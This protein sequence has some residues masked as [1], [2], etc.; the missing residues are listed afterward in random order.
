MTKDLLLLNFIKSICVDAFA[1]EEQIKL[2]KESLPSISEAYKFSKVIITFEGVSANVAPEG[3]NYSHVLFDSNDSDPDCYFERVFNTPEGSK[4]T[5]VFYASNSN[6]WSDDDKESIESLIQLIYIVHG[7]ARIGRLLD[8]AASTDGDTGLPNARGFLSVTKALEADGLLS[9]YAVMFLNI[10]NFRIFT[11]REGNEAGDKLIKDYFAKLK[12]FCRKDEY[13]ARP[14]GDNG[15]MLIKKENYNDVLLKINE[16]TVPLT[17]FTQTTDIHVDTWVGVYFFSSDISVSEAMSFASIALSTAKA[18]RG[19]GLV[20]IFN[21]QMMENFTHN[22]AILAEFPVAL[23]NNEFTVYYQPKAQIN[24]QELVGAE[25]L[26]RWIKNGTVIPPFEFIPVLE[27]DGLIVDLDFY[28]LDLVCKDIRKWLDEGIEPVR[29]STNFSRHHFHNINTAERIINTLVMNNV[30]GKYIQVEITEMSG[31]NNVDTMLDF[32]KTLHDYEVTVAIDDFGVGY[33]SINM[34]KDYNAD[35]VKIDKSL[36]NDVEINFKARM[37]L[38][39]MI[40]MS[41]SVGMDV[42]VEGVETLNQLAYV[43]D[44]GCNMV[45]GY[46]FDKPLPKEDFV[47]RLQ[48]KTYTI[49]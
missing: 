7:R 40:K 39:N 37:L 47:K 2:Y 33:S 25:G 28:V 16:L 19:V 20:S 26:V 35:I 41:Q 3:M 38:E 48:N 8:I 12:S 1:W 45:Q 22:R 42:V 4:V 23:K 34:L 6:P 17:K 13:C 15:I 49:D 9:D 18:G 27:E 36:L 30:P 44:I 11:K 32:I 21:E 10:K 46:F 43:A 29:I 31:Y 14:G 5:I 24:S